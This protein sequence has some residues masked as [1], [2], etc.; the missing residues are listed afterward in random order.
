MN[1]FF[2]KAIKHSAQN[3]CHCEI[4]WFI[5]VLEKKEEKEETQE[6]RKTRIGTMVTAKV[7]E[8]LAE[9]KKTGIKNSEAK[10]TEIKGKW[11]KGMQRST[12]FTLKH[13]PLPAYM[14]GIKIVGKVTEV[15][16]KVGTKELAKAGI[17]VG[18]KESAKFGGKSIA[19]KIPIVGLAAGCAF[20]II[21]LTQGDYL[22]AAME[23]SSGA[24]SLIPGYGTAASLAIDAG[25]VAY[26]LAA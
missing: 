25:L 8:L 9:G 21:R 18:A 16:I 1:E 3:Q 6:K 26:D 20:G 19:K 13:R 24:V 23:V 14:T 12:I 17:K 7:N 22:G 15:G 10:K 5:I 2:L 4:R 11:K